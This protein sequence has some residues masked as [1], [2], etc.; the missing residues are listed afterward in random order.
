M[1]STTVEK[2]LGGYCNALMGKSNR[3][4]TCTEGHIFGLELS[5]LFTTEVTIRV[6]G[7]KQAPKLDCGIS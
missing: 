3:R 5:T 4:M 6:A 1:H 2:N 7:T